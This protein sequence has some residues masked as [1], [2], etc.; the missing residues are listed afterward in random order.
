MIGYDIYLLKLDFHPV[1]VVAL[2]VLKLERDSTKG[3]TIQKN[4]KTE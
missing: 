1:G 4:T 2:L 3:E